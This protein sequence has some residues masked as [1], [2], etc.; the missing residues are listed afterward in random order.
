MRAQP[1]FSLAFNGIVMAFLTPVPLSHKCLCD[2]SRDGAADANRRVVATEGVIAL[3]R[4]NGTNVIRYFPTQAFNFAFKDVYK[5][6]LP[7]EVRI[8]ILNLDI[9][10]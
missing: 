1:K 9:Q 3:W 7:T 4:G 2:M 8:F 5:R 6:L 10:Q